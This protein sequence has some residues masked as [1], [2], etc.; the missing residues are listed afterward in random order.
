MMKNVLMIGLVLVGMVLVGCSTTTQ[1]TPH[2]VA[3]TADPNVARPDAPFPDPAYRAQL[4]L[5]DPLTTL[6]A[7]QKQTINVK[8]KN[9]SNIAWIVYGTQPGVKYR[10]AVGD[11]W[12][13]KDGKVLT[14]MDGRI[15]LPHDLGPGK[16]VD[17]PLVITAPAQA[18]DYVLQLDVVHEGVAWFA[19]K[20]SE[21]LKT[22]VKVQ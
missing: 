8:V 16:D 18:G 12:L 15:G 1:P 17:V 5:V 20:G 14:T 11:A 6:K 9:I 13:D 10:V 22:N 3:N 4:S 19:D 2:P 7:G 21:V